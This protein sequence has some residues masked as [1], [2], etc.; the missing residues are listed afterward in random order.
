MISLEIPSF[1]FFQLKFKILIPTGA[2]WLWI[3]CLPRVQGWG[4]PEADK[5]NR[6]AAQQLSS[7]PVTRQREEVKTEEVNLI[8]QIRCALE[9]LVVPLPTS[10]L[11]RSFHTLRFHWKVQFGAKANANGGFCALCRLWPRRTNFRPKFPDFVPLQKKERVH[12]SQ[13]FAD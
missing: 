4:T 1:S 10:S 6:A 7:S 2:V 5:A 13:R 12:A 9:V 3:N 11:H 8:N